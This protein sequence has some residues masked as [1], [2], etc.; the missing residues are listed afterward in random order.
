MVTHIKLLN[1]KQEETLIVMF[2]LLAPNL[3]PCLF[4][5]CLGSGWKYGSL[6]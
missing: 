1:S 3:G 6:F 5:P 4:L 2:E